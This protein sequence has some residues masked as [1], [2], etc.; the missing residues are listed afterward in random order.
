MCKQGSVAVSA[1]LIAFEAFG[2]FL[3]PEPITAG[4]EAVL[5]MLA[6]IAL[7]A[8]LVAAQ[9][10][11]LKR[12]GSIATRGDRLHYAGDLGANV[13]VIIGIALGAYFALP[14]ADAVAALMIAAWLGWGAF[15]IS[16]DSADHLLDR[17]LADPERA[18]IRELAEAD[19]RIH[20]V[21]DLRT[22]T[23]GPYVHIQFHA[24]LDPAL[25]LDQAHI[26]VVAAEERIRAAYPAADIIIHPDPA[27]QSR[28]ARPRRFRAARYRGGKHVENDDWSAG[29]V[30][31]RGIAHFKPGQR[32][33][34]GRFTKRASRRDPGARNRRVGPSQ[35]RARPSFV[36]GHRPH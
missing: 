15:K 30:F 18:K 22:R 20:A 35:Q 34:C 12:T 24:D 2:R 29:A 9:T 1:L 10:H 5:V 7:T 17:E 6:S 25:T 26:I 36:S 13:V 16:R 14:W 19:P 11:A 21:H 27:R 33:K 8:G 3:V 28:T 32:A 23:S 31:V 4:R